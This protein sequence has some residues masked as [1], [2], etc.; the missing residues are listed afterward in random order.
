[1]LLL[2][3]SGGDTAACDDPMRQS[4]WV[5]RVASS[6][7]DG[8]E[9]VLQRGAGGAGAAGRTVW[10]THAPVALAPWSP[11][12]AGD[13]VTAS[14]PGGAAPSTGARVVVV[15]RNPLDVAVSMY[16]HTKDSSAFGCPE[17]SPEEFVELFLRG[18]VC[19]RTRAQSVSARSCADGRVREPSSCAWL[20]MCLARASCTRARVAAR[21]GLVSMSPRP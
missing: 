7:R 14:A 20:F 19:A 4:P 9:S 15:V 8:F 18:G 6:G 13:G 3:L 12:P 21:R 17:I 1:M 5:E 11:L 2:L 10:K 16:H